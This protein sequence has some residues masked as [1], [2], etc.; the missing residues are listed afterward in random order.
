MDN[1]EPKYILQHYA[2]VKAE[3]TELTKE[4][5]RVK[6][7]TL[8]AV[9]TLDPERKG[10]TIGNLGTFTVNLKKDWQYSEKV[11][12]LTTELKELQKDEQA[13]GT[14]TYEET[15]ILRFTGKK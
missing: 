4:L 5:D 11:G 13:D 7:E 14:A 2:E 10:I 12:E 3:I 1:M 6:E 9:N 8:E 15:E